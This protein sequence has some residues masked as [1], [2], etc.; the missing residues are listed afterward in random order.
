M[1]DLIISIVSLLVGWV[2]GARMGWTRAHRKFSNAFR[3]VKNKDALKIVLQEME[4]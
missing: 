2:I 1:Y 3:R 4:R